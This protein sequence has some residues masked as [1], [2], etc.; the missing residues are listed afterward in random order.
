M[1]K[2]VVRGCLNFGAFDRRW[3]CRE[4]AEELGIAEYRCPYR[5]CHTEERV[6]VNPNHPPGGMIKIGGGEEIQV[7]TAFSRIVPEHE[8]DPIIGD[9]VITL[10]NHANWMYN[11]VGRIAACLTHGR[12][13][14]HLSCDTVTEMTMNDF[15]VIE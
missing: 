13:L 12:A 6:E 15:V 8:R 7:P 2:C 11:S 5:E 1:R 10:R 9:Y 4:H 3:H 14:I